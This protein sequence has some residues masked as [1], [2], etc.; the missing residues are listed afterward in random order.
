MNGKSASCSGLGSIVSSAKH[1]PSAPRC[2]PQRNKQKV[3]PVCDVVRWVVHAKAHMRTGTHTGDRAHMY[4]RARAN[5]RM[6]IS[7]HSEGK[8]GG[9]GGVAVALPPRHLATKH[10]RHVPPQV[11][12]ERYAM[13]RRVGHKSYALV[14]NKIP[15]V[16]GPPLITKVAGREVNG[17]GQ[18]R[19][20]L[21]GASVRPGDVKAVL[22]R[23]G[24]VAATGTEPPQMPLACAAEYAP[25]QRDDTRK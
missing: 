10:T 11:K 22:V 2:P 18:R 4:T 5:R 16:S 6:H 21:N 7:E 8:E 12:I 25:W 24:C 3:D 9:G 15:N 1:P 13:L 17:G 14:A 23:D 20:G 19:F